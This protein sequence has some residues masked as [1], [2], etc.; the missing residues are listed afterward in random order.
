MA[1][2]WVAEGASRLHVV[3]LD[4]AFEG[5]PVHRA[6][7]GRIA[8]SVRVPVQTGGGLRT[9]QD[10]DALLQEGVDRVILGTRAWSQPEELSRLADRFGPNLAVGIDARDGWVQIRGWTETT[11][12]R[13]V[14]LARRA[15]RLGIGT[16]VYTDT[17]RDGM[18]RG[19]NVGAVRELA[20]SVACPVIASGGITS[21]ADIDALR[22]LDL[23]NLA[24]AIV[25]KALYEG[26]VTLRELQDGPEPNRRSQS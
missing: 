21:R 5:R 13:A 10:L 3:D 6:A 4:G 7:I 1:R 26:A 14:D 20:Q 12:M 2:H 19:V 25:G 8:R 23:P 22:A 18:L 11:A 17:S 9:D 15:E 16:L 24:G